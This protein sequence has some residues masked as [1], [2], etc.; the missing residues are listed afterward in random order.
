MAAQPA[1]AINL[2]STTAGLVNFDGV[3]TFNTTALVQYN[4]LVAATTS[5]IQNEA[6]GVAGTVLMSNGVAAFPTFQALPFTKMPWTDKA[7][8][9]A[10]ASNNGYFCTA[11]L[12]ATLPAAPAQGDVIGIVAIGAIVV[13][14]TANTGQVIAIGKARSA[15][16]G[17][18]ASNFTGDAILLYYHVA[19]TT[20]Y[21]V[22]A[23]EGTWTIT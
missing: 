8:S 4:V 18:A 2:N 1:N 10:A 20:W 21:S 16:A 14:I 13:T 23:P 15:A 12:T 3:A 9:F 7:I 22:G 11:T 6:P 17:T 19:D 5:T